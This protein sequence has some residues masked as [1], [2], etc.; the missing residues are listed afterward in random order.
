MHVE[1][2]DHLVLTVKNINLTVKFYQDVMGMKK[3]VFGDNRTALSFGRQKINL[4]ELGN[5]FE[6]KAGSVQSGSAD[7][8]FIVKESIEQAM[9]HLVNHN[10]PLIEGPVSSTGATGKIISVYFRDPDDN[11][12][13]ISNYSNI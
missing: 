7:L 12:I 2:I 4:H 3:I 10:I 1:S 9:A 5:E 8:C 11:L 6:P 13:E